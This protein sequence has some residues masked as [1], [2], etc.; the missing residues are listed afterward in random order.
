MPTYCFLCE[1]CGHGFEEFLSI[2]ERKNPETNSCV[3]C[4]KT[5]VKSVPA[6]VEIF[7]DSTMT[8]N[9]KTKGDWGRLM[10]KMKRGLP[11]RTHETLDKASSRTSRR[12]LG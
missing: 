6:L 2:S 7:S 12:Y 4:G 1:S 8:P 9:K 10:N 11:K 3:R 5:E